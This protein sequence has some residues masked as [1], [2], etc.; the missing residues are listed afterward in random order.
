MFKGFFVCLKYRFLTCKLYQHARNSIPIKTTQV[1][2]VS[3]AG[4]QHS[5]KMSGDSHNCW[6]IEEFLALG[7]MC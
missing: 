6:H 4:V 1:D 7:L 3:V 5:D 2:Y